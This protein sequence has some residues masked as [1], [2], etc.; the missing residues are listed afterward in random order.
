M[1][2]RSSSEYVSSNSGRQISLGCSQKTKGTPPFG[3]SINISAV[4]SAIVPSSSTGSGLRLFEPQ[5]GPLADDTQDFLPRVLPPISCS[6]CF[7]AFAFIYRLAWPKARL[8]MVLWIVGNIVKAEQ[9]IRELNSPFFTCP[10]TIESL[11]FSISANDAKG[12]SWLCS[13]LLLSHK[14]WSSTAMLCFTR[15]L[16]RKSLSSSVQFASAGQSCDDPC[17]RHRTDLD[18]GGEPPGPLILP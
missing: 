16:A 12:D 9:P 3:I 11:G 13:L 6:L 7:L 8:F 4:D 14:H 2:I 15:F 17:V 5:F 18:V 10:L 1:K